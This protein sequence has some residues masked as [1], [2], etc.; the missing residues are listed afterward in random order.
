[1]VY[2]ETEKGTLQLLGVEDEEEEAS[3]SDWMLLQPGAFGYVLFGSNRNRSLYV[4][5]A[6]YTNAR[7]WIGDAER[8]LIGCH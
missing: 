8:R 3:Q 5:G 6:R 2:G 1:M 7:I 4:H